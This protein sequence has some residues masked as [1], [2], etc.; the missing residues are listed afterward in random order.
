MICC[1]IFLG[2][3]VARSMRGLSVGLVASVLSFTRR[4][5]PASSWQAGQTPCRASAGIFAP[6]FSQTLLK[7]IM[8]L[9]WPFVP[10]IPTSL[11]TVSPH[12]RGEAVERRSGSR[13]T[14]RRQPI[15]L[16]KGQ[17]VKSPKHLPRATVPKTTPRQTPKC[18]ET[19]QASG[20]N[21]LL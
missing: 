17:K 4:P 18:K 19:L 6:H 20:K 9:A 2:C 1:I 14:F 10:S 15:S 8:L 13:T 16:Q 3:G 12:A 5:R 7:V 11:L 21:G